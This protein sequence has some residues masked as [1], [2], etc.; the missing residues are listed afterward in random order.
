MAF[1]P[2]GFSL[3]YGH[4]GHLEI[5][6][7]SI[8]TRSAAAAWSPAGQKEEEGTPAGGCLFTDPS[9]HFGVT[10]NKT[11][12]E[13]HLIVL[14]STRPAAP[15][16]RS[17]GYGPIGCTFAKRNTSK[18]VGVG[19]KTPRPSQ[20]QRFLLILIRTFLLFVQFSIEILKQVQ[21]FLPGSVFNFDLG[22]GHFN[23]HK[24]ETSGHLFYPEMSW[25]S[26][27]LLLYSAVRFLLPQRAHRLHRGDSFSLSSIW[28]L[29]GD[30][31]D[32]LSLSDFEWWPLWVG[33]DH[34]AK[35][36]LAAWACLA[37]RCLLLSIPLHQ[38]AIGPTRDL[39]E[40]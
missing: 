15:Y 6:F 36:H 9:G 32:I 20:K 38:T 40:W 2:R 24:W 26:S 1:S 13:P 27:L 28:S 37:T 35:R 34:L 23:N 21:E 25:G 7:R 31:I 17:V 3:P 4:C 8:I 39:A 33:G 22:R 30:S 29:L 16:L 11:I 10:A 18:T 12:V 5:L 19:W 14:H